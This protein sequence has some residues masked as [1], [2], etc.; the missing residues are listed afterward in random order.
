[1]RH[2]ALLLATL[3]ACAPA[4]A[5]PPKGDAA[6]VT[7]VST[8]G[9]EGSYTF[10]VS[11]ESPDVD[12]SQYASWWEVVTPEGALVYRRVLMHAHAAEQPFS[13]SGGPVDVKADQEVIVRAHLHPGGYGRAAMKG[14]AAGGFTAVTLDAG[15]ADG[16]KGADPQPTECWY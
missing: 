15:W 4:G 7:A 10:S 1:M 5:Q 11:V 16:L 9:S 13:R 6:K 14:T 3:A 8:T 12:C 2:S